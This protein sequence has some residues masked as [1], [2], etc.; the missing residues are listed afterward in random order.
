MPWVPPPPPKKKNQCQ[1]RCIRLNESLLNLLSWSWSRVDAAEAVVDQ[2]GAVQVK[3]N[4]FILILFYNTD[5]GF[6]YKTMNEK[7]QNPEISGN[8]NMTKIIWKF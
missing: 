1:V 2:A 8:D 4:N 3:Y 6:Q 7:V 5:N